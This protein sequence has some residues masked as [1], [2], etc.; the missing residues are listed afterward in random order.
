MHQPSHEDAGISMAARNCVVLHVV[1]RVGG[2]VPLAVNSYIKTT[3]GAV[4]HLVTAPFVEGQPAPCWLRDNADFIDLGRG[5]LSRILRL[6]RIV[7]K[8]RP[9]V[10]HAHSSF[11][12]LYMRV[13][14]RRNSKLRLV[15]SPHCFSFERGDLSRFRRHIFRHLERILA[16]NTTALLT[17]SLNELRIAQQLVQGLDVTVEYAPN[18]STLSIASSECSPSAQRRIVTAGRIAPQKDPCYFVRTVD[19]IRSSLPEA[20]APSATWAGTGDGPMTSKLQAAGISVS[21]WLI[22]R[23]LVALYQSASLYIHTAAWE[24]FPL[25]VLDAHE[26]GLPILVRSIPAFEGIQDALTVERGLDQMI[27]SMKVPGGYQDW[28]QGNLRSWDS[29]LKNNTA[30]NQKHALVQAWAVGSDDAA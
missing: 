11:A 30:I 18:I 23:A 26:C 5:H 14:L 1:D 17:C 7:A 19:R 8:Y 22:D 10:V 13:A 6:R 3:T 20:I 16:H 21:G 15:Y 12:G 24:G 28:V 2:G 27:A 4:R 9:D 25:A 29:Y